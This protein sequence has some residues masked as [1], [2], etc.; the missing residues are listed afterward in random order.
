MA[1]QYVKVAGLPFKAADEEQ[2]QQLVEGAGA[3]PI[4]QGQAAIS[5]GAQSDISQANQQY[6]TAGQAL[7]GG[8]S[9]LTLGL[10]PGVLGE[11]GL[12]PKNLIGAAQTSG[13]YTAGDIAG[14]LLPAIFSGGETLAARGAVGAERGLLGTALGLTP[15]G[16][17]GRLGGATERLAAN[18]IPES[19]GLMGRAARVPLGMA[20]RGA[21]EGA[22]INMGHYVGDSMIQNKPLAAEAMLGAGADGALFGG[23]MGGGLGTVGAVGK[24][25]A[26]ALGGATARA[27][28]SR[29]GLGMVARR[30]GL[31]DETVA[32][33]EA[34]PGGLKQ[35]LQ[36]A[37]STLN[38]GLTEGEK[39]LTYGSRTSD[40]AGGYA[41]AEELAQRSRAGVVEDLD[42][43]GGSHLDVMTERLKGRLEQDVLG[44]YRGTVLQKTAAKEIDRVLEE[45]GLA[46]KPGNVGGP[47]GKPRDLSPPKEPKKVGN[48]EYAYR[49]EGQWKTGT[50]R[51]ARAAYESE[52]AAWKERIANTP[53]VKEGFVPEKATSWNQWVKT[54]DSL[55]GKASTATG[56]K[57]AVLQDINN[58]FKAAT[59][60]GMEG[61]EKASSKAG[62][63]DKFAASDASL[64]MAKELKVTVGKKAAAELLAHETTFTPRDLAVMGGMSA[65]GHPGTAMGWLAAKGLGR[66]AERRLAP[67]MAEMAYQASVG[68]RAS[69][70]TISAQS[71]IREAVTNFFKAS[72]QAA[73]RNAPKLA[74]SRTGE[75][76]QKYTRAAFEDAANR[77]EQLISANHRAK[78]EGVVNQ[79]MQMGYGD[80]AK[81]L[82]DT[83]MRATQYMGANM[84]PRKGANGMTNLRPQPKIHG[85]DM[86]EFKFL[87]QDRAIKS[88]FSLLEDMN[89]GGVS[90]DSVQAVKYVY[91][92]IH[93]QIVQEATQQI[94]EIKREGGHLPMDKIATLGIVL[95]SPID[96]T[97]TPEFIGEV[98]M[99]MNNKP[100]PAGESPEPQTPPMA[101]P[102]TLSPDSK[103]LL[104]PSD[105]ALT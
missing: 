17:A 87:R 5:Y 18:L 57:Q 23:L 66:V 93:A 100:K 29:A 48:K 68:Q 59:R 65:L 58:V 69:G 6:G 37:R 72:G 7:L 4:T 35:Y 63:A 13:A 8:I 104:A 91:P 85:L 105:M 20:A 46:E 81:S 22:L 41:R 40:I 95:D 11:L 54:L 77:T 16:L 25:G 50:F 88:P 70:A 39:G 98:Q 78:V 75:G 103:Q 1:E 12:A 62:L 43:V 49:E 56:V 74:E 90:R 99:A 94:Y 30:L 76:K 61:V 10:G 44:K 71:R 84:P 92:E 96:S 31:S 53:A 15:M 97:L 24:L 86:K 38:E 102:G 82:S 36:E 32:A 55:E 33:A 52:V 89:R 3:T 21:T 14:T 28:G 83:N 101:I 2:A 64:R 67:A 45:L 73:A 51:E 19:A 42:K 27:G 80:F 26:E 9:G 79:L 34:R 47:P 60:E